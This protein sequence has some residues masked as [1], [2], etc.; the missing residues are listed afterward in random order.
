MNLPLHSANELQL[1][2]ESIGS[3]QYER[4]QRYITCQFKINTT[5]TESPRAN[6]TDLVAK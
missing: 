4:L 6:R 2:T 3:K 1:N 5:G